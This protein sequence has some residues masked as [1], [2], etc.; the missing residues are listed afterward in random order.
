MYLFF[1]DHFTVFLCLFLTAVQLYDWTIETRVVS[2]ILKLQ[3]AACD[4][5]LIYSNFEFN[6]HFDICAVNCHQPVM[7][8]QEFIIGF[9][10]KGYK[11]IWCLDAV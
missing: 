7:S 10:G 3:P 2:Y 6:F 1:T 9:K 8:Y 5:S 11:S 4:M